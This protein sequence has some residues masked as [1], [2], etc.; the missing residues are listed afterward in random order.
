MD[1]FLFGTLQHVPLL[2]AVSGDADVSSKM[3]KA[4]LSGYGVER[5]KGHVFPM[6]GTDA[7][8]EAEGVIVSDLD[9]AAFARLDYYEKVFGYDRADF[10][11]LDEHGATRR[12]TAYLPEEGRWTPAEA[13][14][15]AGW[16]AKFGN[17]TT[18]LAAQEVLADMA[19]TTH[20]RMGQNYSQVMARA[21]SRLRAQSEGSTGEMGRD[22]IQVLQARNGYSGFFKVEEMD[23][24]FKQFDGGVSDPVNRA[25]F[26]GVDCAIVLPYDP[27]R[28]RVLVVEQFRPG[29]YYRGDLNPWTIEP[30]AGRIDPGEEPEQAATREAFEEA[31]VKL[32]ALHNVSAAYPSPGTTSEYFFIYVGLCDLP[33]D[34]AGVGGLVSEAE[35]IRSH[36][37]DWKDFDRALNAG[38]FNLLPLLAAG[39]WLARNRDALRAA[40]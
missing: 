36:I 22:D 3:C 18:T 17:I 4:V 13:W 6:L 35:D 38:D 27:V 24:T 32:S 8:A 20:V 2:E 12:V 5:V 37:M 26:V 28:D 29:A 7:D 40:A 15:L 30:I 31:G 33:D 14:D 23:L 39:H 1:L 25:V 34:A 16:V 19:S 11:V 10:T 21:A 9:E